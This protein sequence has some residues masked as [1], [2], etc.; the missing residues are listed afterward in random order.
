MYFRF[1]KSDILTILGALKLN[2]DQ[3]VLEKEYVFSG[4]EPLCLLLACSARDRRHYGL[5]K[6]FGRSFGA[7]CTCYLHTV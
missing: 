4:I 7:L 6:M 3:V 2:G 5:E 1:G